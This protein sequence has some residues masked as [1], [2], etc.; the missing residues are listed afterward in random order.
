MKLPGQSTSAGE[1]SDAW[2][3]D[4]EPG[5]VACSGAFTTDVAQQTSGYLGSNGK[6]VNLDGQFREAPQI[7]SG[8]LDEN[9]TM[10]TPSPV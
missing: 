1:L 10:V 8:V 6:V 3:T 4:S 2:S 7:D 5:F 9:T